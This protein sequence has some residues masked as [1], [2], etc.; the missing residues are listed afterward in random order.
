MHMVV[1]YGE[2]CGVEL[3][4]EGVVF[5]VL[6][7]TKTSDC[8]H[9][10]NFFQLLLSVPELQQRWIALILELIELCAVGPSRKDLLLC[11]QVISSC[12]SRRVGPGRVGVCTRHAC[13]PEINEAHKPFFNKERDWLLH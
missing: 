3:V 8:A 7:L 5:L 6:V 10:A 4:I 12:R 1:D 11:P 13:V 2:N 9:L